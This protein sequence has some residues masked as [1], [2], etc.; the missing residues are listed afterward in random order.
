[1]Q[2]PT[3]VW[4][5]TVAAAIL[6]VPL[7]Y[8]A[9]RAYDAIARSEPN[10]ALVVWTPHIAVFWRITAAA[11]VAGM[12]A[13]VARAAARRDPLRVLRVLEASVVI[14]GTLLALQGLCLP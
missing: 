1:V 5:P 6:S 13:F 11:Y 8:A 7:T 10:P 14:V 2:R 12:V 3:P 9:L 4:I